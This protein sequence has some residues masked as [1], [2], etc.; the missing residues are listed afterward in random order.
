LD[1]LLLEVRNLKTSFFTDEGVAKSVDDVSFS[2]RKAEIL[3][4]IGESGCGKSVSALSILRLVPSPPGK[5]IGGSILFEGQDLLAKSATAMRDIRGNDIAMIFQEPMT[6]LNPVYTIGNQISENIIS[7]QKLG[8][9]A[10]RQQAIMM[11]NRVGISSPE[12]RID[13]YPH[14]L[15][16]GMRQRAMIAMALSCRPKLL[17][18]DEPTT[19][20]DVTIQAQILEIIK[21]LRQEF[22]MAVIMITHDLGIIAELAD[23]V[24]VVYAGKV[25]ET[26][27]VRSIFRKPR[28][29]YTQALYNS[30]PQLTDTR[31]QRL[32]VIPGT[33]PN[34]LN[35]PQGCRFHP[36]CNF[37]IDICSRREPQL[38]EVSENHAVRCFRYDKNTNKHF[39]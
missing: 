2:V 21:K 12:K 33:V 31:K 25:V 7:H 29:P 30:I 22:G 32:E 6:S 26:A 5:I 3:G 1:D 24:A 14:Q 27:D 13:E 18:A 20:L 15:S 10:A 23:K 11:L 28:H 19:A 39:N 35:F 8:R 37:A 4:I 9:K 17:I 34:P 38:E 16:G 36:R